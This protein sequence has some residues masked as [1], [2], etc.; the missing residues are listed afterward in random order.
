MKWNINICM[1]PS[2]CV[3]HTHTQTL[4]RRWIIE[5]LVTTTK[6]VQGSDTCVT[7][8]MAFIIFSLFFSL[9]P[10]SCHPSARV[11]LPSILPC[12]VVRLSSPPRYSAVFQF[13]SRARN[14]AR[15]RPTFQS[16]ITC[17]RTLYLPNHPDLLGHFPAPSILLRRA[18]F[19][20]LDGSFGIKWTWAG[21][22][23]WIDCTATFE[24]SSAELKMT[25]LFLTGLSGAAIILATLRFRITE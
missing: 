9:H 22:F 2:Q 1:G 24:R 19:I 12:A 7:C 15:T 18:T 10:I 23:N 6:W 13:S 20:L 11:A 3:L 21:P 14:R 5:W 25:L 16:K 17:L 8:R 4:T